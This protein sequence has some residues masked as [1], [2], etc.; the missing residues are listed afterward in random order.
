MSS[1]KA[2]ALIDALGFRDISRVNDTEKVIGALQK[3][4]RDITIGARVHNEMAAGRMSAATFSDTTVVT[5]E[6]PSDDDAGLRDA[7][8]GLGR[9]IGFMLTHAAEG[10]PALIYRGCITAGQLE[11]ADNIFVGPAI[12]EAAEW[13]EQADG[14]MIWLT[15]AADRIASPGFTNSPWFFRYPIPLKGGG[16]LETLAINPLWERVQ[17]NGIEGIG[18]LVLRLLAPFDHSARVEVVRKRQNTYAFLHAA[19]QRAREC[20]ENEMSERSENDG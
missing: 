19:I 20:L 10:D 1:N 12:N 4:K 11:V 6:P 7:I 5:C 15:P 16:A 18:N 9:N 8:E 3:T 14:A 17:A 13:Y 2:I